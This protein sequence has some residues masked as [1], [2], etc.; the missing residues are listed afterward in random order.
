M[1]TKIS[2]KV[3]FALPGKQVVIPLKVEEGSTIERVICC[4]GILDLFP[5]ID[6]ERHK[7]GVFGKLQKLTDR[8]YPGDRVE[9][10]RDLIIDPKEARRKKAKFYSVRF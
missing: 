4:S 1:D 9:I 2:V 6:L 5:E 8:V 3:A 10:Y 7:V